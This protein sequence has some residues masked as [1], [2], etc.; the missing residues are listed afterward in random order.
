MSNEGN[1]NTSVKQ[2]Y[3]PVWMYS[4]MVE[5]YKRRKLLS[6]ISIDKD[7]DSTVTNLLNCPW[8]IINDIRLHVFRLNKNTIFKTIYMFFWNTFG[9]LSSIIGIT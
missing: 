2:D 7:M 8:K 9:C 4:L 3:N 1:N 5:T 6:K